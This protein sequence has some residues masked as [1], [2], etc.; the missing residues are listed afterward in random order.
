MV[1]AASYSSPNDPSTSLKC[2]LAGSAKSD[3]REW[4]EDQ[5][6]EGGGLLACELRTESPSSPRKKA[7]LAFDACRAATRLAATSAS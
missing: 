3:R 2:E 6:G 1:F 7:S 5:A 4:Q